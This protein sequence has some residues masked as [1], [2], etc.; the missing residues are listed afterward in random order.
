MRQIAT[1]AVAPPSHFHSLTTCM[2][3]RMHACIYFHATEADITDTRPRSVCPACGK[4][5]AR[6]DVLRKHLSTSCKS[7]RGS[8]GDA[9]APLTT[10]EE[11]ALVPRKRRR[12]QRRNTNVSA[13]SP[14]GSDD[15]NPRPMKQPVLTRG[16]SYPSSSSSGQHVSQHSSLGLDI[17]ERERLDRLGRLDS[18]LNGRL[19]GRAEGNTVPRQELLRNLD[20][21]THDSSA[22]SDR[23]YS[24]S[25]RFDDEPRFSRS[26]PPPP[27]LSPRLV[28]DEPRGDVGAD[29]PAR[30]GASLD[31]PLAP[32]FAATP[33]TLGSLSFTP[34]AEHDFPART[35]CFNLAIGSDGM[36]A[37][38][39]V[40]VGS[41]GSG[42][43][44]NSV[45]GGGSGVEFPSVM[46]AE[47]TPELSWTTGSESAESVDDLFSWLFNVA[48]TTGQGTVWP[49]TP[50]LDTASLKDD[51]M[52]VGA[53]SDLSG[54]LPTPPE[55]AH[56]ILHGMSSPHQST[57]FRALPPTGTPFPPLPEHWRDEHWCLP[58]AI[59]QLDS[60]AREEVLNLFEGSVRNDMLNP[61]FSLSQMRLYFELYFT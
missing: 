19:D 47:V 38:S 22:L 33:E 27:S 48:N 26:M 10:A 28:R 15:G 44:D 57:H 59:D 16:Y 32:A 51:V 12:P 46:P 5:F 1:S 30:A 13:D 35:E 7:R 40:D 45:H 2:R 29:G 25:P 43:D 11:D 54:S 36:P 39:P 24:T 14:G 17:A 61:A 21:S 8:D 60:R 34:K 58:P 3:A 42:D 37:L 52:V 50:G 20:P 31:L 6:P 55:P 18:R 41:A 23:E 53:D 4:G 9:P 49:N 56:S